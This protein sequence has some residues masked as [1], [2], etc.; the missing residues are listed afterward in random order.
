MSESCYAIVESRV[1]HMAK[2]TLGINDILRLQEWGK[3]HIFCEGHK[4]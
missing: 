1:S 3:V 4:I 2:S